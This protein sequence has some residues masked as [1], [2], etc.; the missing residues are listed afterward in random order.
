MF[1]H[2]NRLRLKCCSGQ[3]A[4]DKVIKKM[5]D[6]GQ[7]NHVSHRDNTVVSRLIVGVAWGNNF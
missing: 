1:L 3:T 7:S 5:I 6:V 2:V 4:I